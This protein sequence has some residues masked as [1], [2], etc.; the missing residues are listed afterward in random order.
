MDAIEPIIAEIEDYCRESG[1]AESTFGRRA[2]NDGK[3]VSRIRGGGGMTTR[4]LARVRRF[5]GEHAKPADK[6]AA[7]GEMMMSTTY[8]TR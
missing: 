2:V 8:F 4:T 7:D 6:P 1:M 5:I 3:F